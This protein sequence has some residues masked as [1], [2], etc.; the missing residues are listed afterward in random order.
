MDFTS[1]GIDCMTI[2]DALHFSYAGQTSSQHGLYQI[3]MNSGMLEEPFLA[4]RTIREERIRGRDE[5]YFAGVDYAPL[6]FTM[7]FAF[8]DTWSESKI[9]EVA[10]W[11]NQSSY[12]PLF[13]T[14]NVDRIFYCM[15]VES[16]VLIHNALSQGYV[17]LTMRCDSP[18]SYSPIYEEIHDFSNNSPSG[19][20]I[21]IRNLGDTAMYPVIYAKVSGSSF[22]LIQLSDGGDKLAFSNLANGETVTID[23][24]NETVET[25]IPLTYRYDQMSGDSRYLRFHYGH[26]R[27]KV[28]GNVTLKFRYQY[29]MLQ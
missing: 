6:E 26:N 11:L 13:F 19:S 7:S 25:D 12:Q 17:T 18:Y 4:S 1:W 27:L 21:V 29:K 3:H 8:D 24:Q 28:I 5:P 9:R 20:E 23:C 22:S 16:P 15:P 10:R 2:R 14:T